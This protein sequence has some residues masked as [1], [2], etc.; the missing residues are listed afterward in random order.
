MKKVTFLQSFAKSDNKDALAT[1]L[2]RN[3]MKIFEAHFPEVVSGKPLLILD[4][5]G[6]FNF[7]KQMGYE[8]K[9]G[10]EIVLLNLKAQETSTK[11]FSSISGDA[12]DLSRFNDNHFDIVFSNS[13]IEHVGDF[14]KQKEMANEVIRVGKGFYVQTPNY[15]FPVEPHFLFLGFQYMPLWLKVFLVRNLK[16]GWTDKTRDKKEASELIDSIQ[17][18]S[19]KQMRKLFPKAKIESE[20]FMGLVKSIMAIKPLDKK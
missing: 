9:P 4:V 11:N 6:T 13:V 5:G 19:K 16:L 17:L 7:W 8:N 15:W 18:L 12:C 14:N 20:Y 2:R 3:R 1:K 10:I